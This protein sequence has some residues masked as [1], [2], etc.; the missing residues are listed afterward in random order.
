MTCEEV[1]SLM[2]EC[3]S[4]SVP[5]PPIVY[6]NGCCSKHQGYVITVFYPGN[7]LLGTIWMGLFDDEAA[8]PDLKWSQI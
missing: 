3:P 6:N 8:L 5:L 2:L 4:D 1:E 7:I